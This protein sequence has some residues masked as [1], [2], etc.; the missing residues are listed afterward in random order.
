MVFKML[1]SLAVR[2]NKATSL[3]AIK[4]ESSASKKAIKLR[5][6]VAVGVKTDNKGNSPAV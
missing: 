5:M 6:M 1:M 2:E 4:K 3:P